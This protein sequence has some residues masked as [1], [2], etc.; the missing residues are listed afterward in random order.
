MKLETDIPAIQLVTLHSCKGLEYPVV[1]C[2]YLWHPAK[3][4]SKKSSAIVRDS[5]GGFLDIGSSRLNPH[6]HRAQQQEKDELQRLTYVAL[7]RARHRLYIGMAA[8]KTKNAAH[9]T[10]IAALLKVNTL[11][12]EDWPEKLKTHMLPPI[13]LP[14]IESGTEA[15]NSDRLSIAVP[16]DIDAWKGTVHR[17][18]SFSSLSSHATNYGSA[19]DHDEGTTE[20]IAVDPGLL[21]G[22]GG[23]ATLGNRIHAILEEIIGNGKKLEDVVA[24]L[25]AVQETLDSENLPETPVDL[26][27]IIDCILQT[28]LDI[29]DSDDQPS[30]ND[31]QS[32]SI[33]EMHFLL[34]LNN[35][36]SQKLSQALLCDN[37]INTQTESAQWA[38]HIQDESF[39][40]FRGFM[41][42]FIDLT[43]EYKGRWY[44]ADYKTNQLPGYSD[45]HLHHAMLE[46]DYLLQARIYAV[47]LHRHLQTH[48]ANYDYATHFGGCV[49]LFV[50]GFPDNGGVW[51]DCP[52][53]DGITALDALFEQGSQ[54]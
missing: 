49:Y 14:E 52:H 24:A 20:N 4:S 9:D 45:D 54:S 22:L 36:T 31:L 35:L 2:P 12:R 5:K 47:A 6:V 13:D 23:G 17:T 41:Q 43:F 21:D 28:P 46:N 37:V 10:P 51:F 34:P 44:I 32:R 50:R 53:I 16:S 7:T 1:F 8:L 40:K 11:A 33:A 26:R 38:S 39:A 27:K 42:G 18:S 25:P 15:D 48:L 19:K 29:S 3:G 30:L